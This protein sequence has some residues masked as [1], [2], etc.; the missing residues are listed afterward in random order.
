MLHTSQQC[1]NTPQSFYLSSCLKKI[2]I[3]TIMQRLLQEASCPT[4]NAFWEQY[5]SQVTNYIDPN[6]LLVL[7]GNKWLNS[8]LLRLIVGQ[9]KG[10]V[11]Q[12]VGNTEIMDFAS[13]KKVVKIDVWSLCDGLQLKSDPP[14]QNY[15]NAWVQIL[16]H[17]KTIRSCQQAF[18]W[19]VTHSYQVTIT[20]IGQMKFFFNCSGSLTP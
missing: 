2:V 6:I 17:S 19:Q 16:S 18:Y 10:S 13:Y 20:V 8:L 14:P 9:K 4:C 1:K 12:C 5:C 3:A 15:K 7:G 11:A